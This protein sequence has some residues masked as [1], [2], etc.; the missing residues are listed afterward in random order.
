MAKKL[1]NVNLLDLYTES[2]IVTIL[3]LAYLN[4][5]SYIFTAW[6]PAFLPKYFYY[7]MVLLGLPVILLNQQNFIKAMYTPFTLWCIVYI[8]VTLILST[9]AEGK[10]ADVAAT[11]MQYIILAMY[12][13]ILLRL[14]NTSRWRKAFPVIAIVVAGA[15]LVD[16]FFP[17]LL[18]PAGSGNRIIGRANGFQ[19]NTN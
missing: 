7:A 1:N 2:V 3:V 14:A 12:F 4:I 15:T 19:P 13:A 9:D 17:E 16:F 18:W 6:N 8:V 10:S 11:R 5:G